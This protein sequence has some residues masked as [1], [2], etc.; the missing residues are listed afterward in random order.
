MDTLTESRAIFTVLFIDEWHV[1][2]RKKTV[3][4]LYNQRS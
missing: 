2:C 1:L 4:V 3:Q